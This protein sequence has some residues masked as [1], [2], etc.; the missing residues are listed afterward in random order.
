[1]IRSG[2]GESGRGGR[3]AVLLSPA[4]PGLASSESEFYPLDVHP[5][6]NRD[7]LGVDAVAMVP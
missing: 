7:C 4:F 2:K 3:I 1:M 6:A 5:L